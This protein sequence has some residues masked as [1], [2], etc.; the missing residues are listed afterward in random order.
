MHTASV[1]WP[2]MLYYIFQIL[3][4]KNILL[5]Y[6]FRYILFLTVICMAIFTWMTIHFHIVDIT[7]WYFE[8]PKRFEGQSPKKL[9]LSKW[10]SNDQITWSTDVGQKMTAV[11]L[12]HALLQAP[13]ELQKNGNNLTKVCAGRPM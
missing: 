9:F 8:L 12:L 1:R 4:A 13:P 3:K 2:R 10:C 7:H 5:F 6:N 11:V